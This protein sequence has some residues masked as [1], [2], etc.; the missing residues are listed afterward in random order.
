MFSIERS[1]YYAWSKHKPGKRKLSNE[2]LD[3]KIIAIFTTHKDRYGA[4]RITD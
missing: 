4:I 3:K 2:L 1:G